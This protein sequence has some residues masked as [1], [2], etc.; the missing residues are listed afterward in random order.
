MNTQQTQTI[1][2]AENNKTHTT[3]NKKTQNNKI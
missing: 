2:K 1:K 3:N